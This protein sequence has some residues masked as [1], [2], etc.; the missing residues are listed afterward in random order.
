MYRYERM[1]FKTFSALGAAHQITTVWYM[2]TSCVVHKA[3]ILHKYKI[4]RSVII[5]I[6]SHALRHKRL[7]R[8]LGLGI[9][10]INFFIRSFVR[11]FVSPFFFMWSEDAKIH[12]LKWPKTIRSSVE[13]TVRQNIFKMKRKKKHIYTYEIEAWE[14]EKNEAKHTTRIVS[15]T[16]SIRFSKIIFFLSHI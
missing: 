10:Y 12:T 1:L 8:S 9:T 6:I 11:Y 2:E 13:S 14:K 4:I 5:I 7:L 3:I 16:F 15:S